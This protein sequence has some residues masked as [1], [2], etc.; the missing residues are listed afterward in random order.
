MPVAAAIDRV[1]QRVAFF[2][3]SSSVLTM[4]RSTSASVIFRGTGPRLVGQAVQAPFEETPPPGAD[5][6]RRNPQPA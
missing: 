4:T 2:G 1:D 5:H 3:F 6:V